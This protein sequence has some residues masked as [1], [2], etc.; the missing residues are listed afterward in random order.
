MTIFIFGNTFEPQMWST[1]ILQVGPAYLKEIHIK[2]QTYKYLGS[3]HSRN[4]MPF[5]WKKSFKLEKAIS[6][7]A[8]HQ[9]GA[10]CQSIIC[11]QKVT[12]MRAVNQRPNNSSC[13]LTSVNQT[14]WRQNKSREPRFQTRLH[15]IAGSL[16]FGECRHPPTQY[17]MLSLQL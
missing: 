12:S 10:P 4:C 13:I 7:T 11:Q 6:Q 1:K 2:I 16:V 3:F 8:Q 5:V 14:A 15:L 17:V 9:T